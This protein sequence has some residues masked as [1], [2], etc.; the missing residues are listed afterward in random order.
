MAATGLYLPSFPYSSFLAE[1]KCRS[2]DAAPQCQTKDGK[3]STV[4]TSAAQRCGQLPVSLAAALAVL[5][6]MDSTMC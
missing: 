6:P 3:C 5:V 2:A 1:V 4:A